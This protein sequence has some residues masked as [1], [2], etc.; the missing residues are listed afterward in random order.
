[1]SAA[2]AKQ[3]I[4]FQD[5]WFRRAT[6]DEPKDPIIF[7]YIKMDV[8][9]LFVWLERQLKPNKAIFLCAFGVSGNARNFKRRNTIVYTNRF[10]E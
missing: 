6:R 10:I 4:F 2:Q 9:K 3:T 7:L 1:M 5:F 8:E